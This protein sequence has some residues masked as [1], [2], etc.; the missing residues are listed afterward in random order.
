MLFLERFL[1]SLP[2]LASLILVWLSFHYE[3][4]F[5]EAPVIFQALLVSVSIVWVIVVVTLG[6]FS[7][8]EFG[9]L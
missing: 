6:V 3:K 1:L 9:I 8:L 7:L 2:V 5:S 4:K